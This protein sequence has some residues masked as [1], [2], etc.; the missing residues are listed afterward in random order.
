[1][2]QNLPRTLAG[3]GCA[4]LVALLS[5][6]AHMDSQTVDVDRLNNAIVRD[7]VGHVRAAVESR[8]LGV[9]QSIA[10][11][12]Y[13]EGTPL[14]TVAARSASLGVM[15]YLISAGAD[16]NARTPINETALMLASYFYSEDRE[17]YATSRARHDEAVR[18]LVAAGAEIEN[19]PYHYT[20]L[21]YAAYQGHDTCVRFLI[22]R[23][24]RVDADAKNGGTYINTP[25]MMAAIQGHHRTAFELLRAGANATIRV[26]GGHTAAEFAEKYRHAALA[27]VLRCAESMAPGETFPQKCE[28][29]TA[30]ESASPRPSLAR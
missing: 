5:A 11:P 22:Q 7:D 10:V 2:R 25:L 30:G 4:F 27:R 8:A 19:D 18:I 17:G 9:N 12:G 1:M 20:P 16:I 13:L 29:T 24:A 6:C 14:L 23:G 28:A 3:A 26:R 15:R 21:S